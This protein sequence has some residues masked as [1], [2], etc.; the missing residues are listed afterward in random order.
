MLNVA[1]PMRAAR[2]EMIVAWPLA[3]MPPG[4]GD[5]N[6]LYGRQTP[7]GNLAYGGGPHEWLETEEVPGGPCPSTPLAGSNARRLAEWLP[8]AA[9]ARVI[10]SWAARHS[11][12][13]CAAATAPPFDQALED[14]HARFVCGGLRVDPQDERPCL[15]TRRRAIGALSTAC[16]LLARVGLPDG[17]RRTIHWGNR[18]A[19]PEDFPRLAVTD[20]RSEIGRDRL[21]CSGGTAAMDLMLPIIAARHGMDL[22]RAGER[23]NRST[24]NAS[25]RRMRTR[26]AVGC[27]RSAPCHAPCSG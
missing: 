3:L 11:A 13:V 27:S 25:A 22:A 16:D 18:A 8:K 7:R 1:I 12:G 26:R 14:C 2:T 20:T 21:T 9:R 17:Y 4:G 5:G 6:G 24:T 19:F 15:A 23:A 10:R